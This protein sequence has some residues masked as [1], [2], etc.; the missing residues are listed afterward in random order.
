MPSH[1]DG[2]LV[3]E[4][5]NYGERAVGKISVIGIPE[6]ELRAIE[7]GEEPVAVVPMYGYTPMIVSFTEFSEVAPANLGIEAE[8]AQG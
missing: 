7:E 5:P 2:Y 4:H 1:E 6:D 8:R 3:F